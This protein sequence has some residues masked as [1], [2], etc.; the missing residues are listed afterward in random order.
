MKLSVPLYILKQ[1]ARV[2]ARKTSVALHEAL[3]STTPTPSALTTSSRGWVPY[4]RTC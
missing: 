3:E 2:Y 4:L 1:Q